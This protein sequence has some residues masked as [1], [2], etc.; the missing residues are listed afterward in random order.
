MFPTAL[1]RYGGNCSLEDLQKG[2][3][4]TFTRYIA[5]DRGVLRL[6][7]DLVDLIDVDDALLGSLGVEI[8]SGDDLEQDVLDVLTHIPRLGEG[9]RVSNGKRHIE[10]SRQGLSHQRLAG[11]SWPDHENVRLLELDLVLRAPL[12][13]SHAFVVVV[14]SHGEHLLGLVLA[15]HVLVEESIDLM[16]LG[17]FGERDLL[18]V[19]E[20]LLDDLVAQLDALIT[21]VHTR[22]CDQLSDL[23][24][25]LAAEAALQ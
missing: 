12:S 14:H 20:L 16:R 2:L 8:C 10:K 3:L 9:G 7:C 4:D 24:L 6:A 21:D 22:P 23:L 17:E 13:S 19:R 25:G 11:A 18:R 15:H 5:C 1:R